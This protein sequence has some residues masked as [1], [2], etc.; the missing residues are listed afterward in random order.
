MGALNL[1]QTPRSISGQQFPSRTGG[2]G[3]HVQ[4]HVTPT[5]SGM[6]NFSPCL[7]NSMPPQQPSPNRLM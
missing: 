4:G 3:S 5:S 7:P 6:P 1:Q 2:N